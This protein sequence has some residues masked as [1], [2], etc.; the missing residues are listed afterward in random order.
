[1]STVTAALAGA[2]AV[3]VLGL[4]REWWRNEQERRGLLRLLAAELDHNAEVLR[5][6]TEHRGDR[7]I[8]WVG[9]PGLPSLKTDTWRE[10]RGRVAALMPNV[11]TDDLNSYYSPLETLLTLLTFKDA[12]LDS[13]Y[14]DLWR[15]IAEQAPGV[16]AALMRNPYEQRL[17]EILNAQDTA[18]SRIDGYLSLS[19]LEPLVLSF[20]GWR[21]RQ[22][23]LRQ[24]Q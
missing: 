1:M 8:D 21:E 2:L 4:G 22:Q 9:A 13:G 19:W 20:R 15:N 5:T 16:N 3:F 18:R 24:Q 7:V 23:A 17:V 6:A 14:R 10:V 11:V 12:A